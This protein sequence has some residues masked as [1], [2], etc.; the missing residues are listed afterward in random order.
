MT[1]VIPSVLPV[2]AIGI[3]FFRRREK[4]LSVVTIEVLRQSIGK[5]KQLD[6]VE[7][8]KYAENVRGIFAAEVKL[9]RDLEEL[10]PT[11]SRKLHRQSEKDE[12]ELVR[13]LADL[14]VGRHSPDVQRKLDELVSQAHQAVEDYERHKKGR[15]DRDG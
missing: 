5:L 3:P 9:A 7:R 14:G 11:E 2:L 4:S 10:D 13:F 8:E 6:A 15:A 12:V 1:D